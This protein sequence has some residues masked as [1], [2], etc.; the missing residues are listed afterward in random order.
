MAWPLDRR[1]LEREWMDD[2]SVD[3]A[4][5]RR[6]L[7]YLR[8]INT[9]LGYHRSIIAHLSR[10]SRRWPRG[11]PVHVLD[12]A[13]GSG[14]L[15]R[16]I[17]RWSGFRGFDLRVVGIDLQDA[18]LREASALMPPGS[19]PAV[20]FVRCDA[21][22]LPFADGAFD[23]AVTSSF[24]HHLDDD[25]A[26]AA[27]REMA[28]VASRGIVVSDILRHRRAY[29]W[30][31][32]LTLLSRPIVKHDGRMSVKQAFTKEEVLR[33]RERAEIGFARYRRHFGHRFTLAGER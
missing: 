24:L 27:L 26:V 12:V 13:T 10:F 23:Y 5:L 14:D 2:P 30:I 3:P 17:C 29:A 31:T 21:L 1:R 6:S 9:F 33:L 22:R 15:P 11:R 18:T 4:E 20:R 32:L 8:R 25:T 19:L 7:S 28:R 16:A